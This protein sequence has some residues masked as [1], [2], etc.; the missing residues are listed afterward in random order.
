MGSPGD[1][2]EFQALSLKVSEKTATEPE[3]AR[4]RELRTRLARPQ[5]PPLP[6]QLPRQ[7]ARSHKKLKVEY[8]P[9]TSMHATFTEEISAGG[10][11]LRV[12]GLLEVGTMMVVRLELGEPG[13][14]T[15]TA[16][17]AWCKRDGGHYFAGLEL[18]GLRDDERERIEAW[19]ALPSPLP[20]RAG[21]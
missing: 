17:V 10:L 14:L 4:W 18:V 13:P 9:V 21:T 19:T 15:L 16:R 12:Q 7:H 20:S 8:A 5:P 2:A 3:R 6:P 1:M 11:K